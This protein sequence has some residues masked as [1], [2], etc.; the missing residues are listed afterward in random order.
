MRETG[1]QVGALREGQVMN[2]RFSPDGRR[3][4]TSQ[5]NGEIIIW[6]AVSFR[7]LRRSEAACSGRAACP[8][9]HA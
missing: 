5:Q 9:V 6:D 8:D 3:I 2:V 7:A 4:A 1:K